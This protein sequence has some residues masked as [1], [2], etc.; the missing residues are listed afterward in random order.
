MP[1]KDI[2]P[3]SPV[4]LAAPNSG[5]LVPATMPG[6]PR[7]YLVGEAERSHRRPNMAGADRISIS[8]N[9]RWHAM[10]GR[11]VSFEQ[12]LRI[13]FPDRMPATPSA[14]TITYRHGAPACPEGILTPGDV[15][16]LAEGLLVNATATYAS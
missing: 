10:R 6:R 1:V 7:F 11:T 12:L 13:A 14:A 4:P 8:V 3:R 2:P 9:G 5:A 16:P 15:I